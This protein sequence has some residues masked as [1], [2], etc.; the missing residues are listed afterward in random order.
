MGWVHCSPENLTAGEGSPLHGSR[1]AGWVGQAHTPG[2]LGLNWR[3]T[4]GALVVRLSSPGGLPGGGY[5]VEAEL[6]RGGLP[7]TPTVGSRACFW[8]R[9]HL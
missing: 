5:G 6:S 8:A 7:S 3:G 9:G 1:Q 2:G 4:S